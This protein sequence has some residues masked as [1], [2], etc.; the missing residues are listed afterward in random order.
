MRSSISRPSDKSEKLDPLRFVVAPH[1]VQDLG[2]NLYTDLPRVLVEFVANAY[3]ADA[4]TA[5]ITMDIDK[6]HELRKQIGRDWDEEKKAAKYSGKEPSRLAEKTLPEGTTIV[7]KDNGCGMSRLDLQKKFL[8][9]GR[10]RREE[11]DSKYRTPGGRI[12]MGRKGLGKLAGFGV[13]QVITI[14]SKTADETHAT[15]IILDYNSLIKVSNTNEIPISEELLEDGGGIDGSGTTIILSKLL[16]EP[17]KS[18]LET[19]ANHVADHFSLIEQEDFRVEL[20]GDVINP[21]P[22]EFVYAWPNPE[23]AIGQ[24]V[25]GS[26]RTEDD[27]LVEFSYRLRFTKE[28]QA[29]MAGERGVRVYAHKRLAAAPSLLNATTNMHGF[30]MTDYLDGVVFADFIDDQPEDYIATDRQTLRWDSPL[31]RQLYDFLSEQ[32]KEACK[33]RQKKRDEDNN[34]AVEKHEFTLNEIEKAELTRKETAAA[35]KMAAAL[36][37]LYK[38]GLEDEGYRHTFK[39]VL[40]GFGQGEILTAL[41]RLS[42]ENDP[43]LD[44]VIAEVTKL[45][46]EELAGFIRFAKGRLNG[47]KALRTIVRNVNFAA[48]RNENKLHKL[49][50]EN[51]WLIDPTYFQFLTS[52]QPQETVFMQLAKELKIGSFVDKKYDRTAAEETKKGGK[53]LRPDLVFL[54]GNHPLNRL[55]IVELKAPNTPLYGAHYRQLQGYVRDAKAWLERHNVLAKVEGILIGSYAEIDNQARDVEWLHEEI[56]RTQNQG[57]YR[58]FGIDELLRNTELVHKDLIDRHK[59]RSVK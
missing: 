5:Q 29:L 28:G 13:A 6:I 12:I 4:K 56:R 3:D 55:V 52:N 18:R 1:I 22:R 24:L 49:F 53:N 11:D 37:G 41:S 34:K 50:N 31:L 2:L 16:Y 39:Q 59:A 46:S 26:Y 8:I 7:I 17:M 27:R 48:K 44:R 57:E 51:P 45:T 15:K 32:I 25:E 14:I 21:T 54:L 40:H 20:N 10:R 33:N 58:V 38:K 42:E 19:I 23:K 36:S 47:I 9:A 35:L 30:R 43:A